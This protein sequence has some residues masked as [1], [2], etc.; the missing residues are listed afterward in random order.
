MPASCAHW[1][2]GD[3]IKR[4]DG[5]EEPL[6]A[7]WRD[8]GANHAPAPSA[9]VLNEEPVAIT[10][11]TRVRAGAARAATPAPASAK[12]SAKAEPETGTR[13]EALDAPRGGKADDL[14]KIKGIGPKLE[15]LCNRLG[16]YHYRS[17]R[18]LDRG[19]GRVGGRQP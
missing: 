8:L 7:P 13:P 14:K 19:G 16:F 2:I 11:Q 12:P 10:G 1:R 15:K 3:T 6:T 17:D 18:E 9:V 5:S 4:I